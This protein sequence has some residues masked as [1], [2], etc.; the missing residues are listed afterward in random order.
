[1]NPMMAAQRRRRSVTYSDEELDRIFGKLKRLN[2]KFSLKMGSV[3]ATPAGEGG[4]GKQLHLAKVMPAA[5]N[6]IE[7]VHYVDP[8][9][10]YNVPSYPKSSMTTT[11]TRGGAGAPTATTRRRQ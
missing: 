10:F 1:M 11:F 6:A 5:L 2:K 8:E 3:L 9:S 4:E 7:K